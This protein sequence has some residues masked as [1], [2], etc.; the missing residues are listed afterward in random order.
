M[1]S[2]NASDEA[3]A[4]KDKLLPA[5]IAPAKKIERKIIYTATINVIVDDLDAAQ[6]KLTELI[7]THQG[8]VASSDVSGEAGS[9]R[10]GTWTIRIPVDQSETFRKA[11]LKFGYPQQNS[12]SSDDVTRQ[13]YSL[14]SRMQNTEATEKRLRKHLETSKETKDTLAIEKELDRV[15]GSIELMKGQLQ[16]WQS[17]STLATVNLTLIERKNYQP[18]QEPTFGNRISQTFAGSWRALTAFGRGLV[19][20][21]VAIGPWLAV[22]A[23]ILVP[24]WW[25]IHRIRKRDALAESR[26]V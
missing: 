8:Y 2:Q 17:L 22:F 6:K 14:E 13:Y 24:I 10:T 23:V 25:W 11:L 7:Q 26:K 15:R 5:K 3:S 1:A 20:F 21:V 18:Q 4:K 9:K 19:L 16:L 12:L